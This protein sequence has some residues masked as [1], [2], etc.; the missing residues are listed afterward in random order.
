MAGESPDRSKQRESSEE[1]T[2]G[3]AGPVPGARGESGA[4]PRD[5]RLAVARE[6]ESTARGGVDMATRVFSRPPLP[7]EAEAAE[8]ADA[9][10]SADAEVAADADADARTADTAAEA[11]AEAASEPESA[12]R[13][14]SA[15]AADGTD[16]TGSTRLR[17]AVAA[18]VASADE[19]EGESEGV[20][21]AAEEH[22]PDG[23]APAGAPEGAEEPA[24]D[25]ADDPGPDGPPEAASGAPG[26]TGGASG[27]SGEDSSEP[28]SA[29]ESNSEPESKSGAEPKPEA[30]A[31]ETESAKSKSG[32]GT[33]SATGTESAAES[34]SRT[35]AESGTETKSAADAQTGTSTESESEPKSGTESGAKAPSETGSS[36]DSR[37]K[38][39]AK[40]DAKV[41]AAAGPASAPDPAPGEDSGDP[42]PKPFVDQPTAVFKAVR[43]PAAPPVDQPT[44]M[45]KL[46]DLAAAKPKGDA[47]ART[48]ADAK[49]DA[50]AAAKAD[51]GADAKSE[52]V[53]ER[54]SKFVALRPLDDPAT[55]KPPPGA[56][57]SAGSSK[58][59]AAATPA[60]KP[61]KVAAAEATAVVP[62]VGPER[63]TQQPLPPLP[64][65]DLLA[66]LTNTPPPRDTAV[67]SIA[68][69]VK[70]WTPVVV[71]LAIVFAVVQAFRP[72]PSP[73]LTLTA[74]DSYT[75]EGTAAALP[76]PSEGQGWM[77]VNGVGTMGKFGDQKPIAI[78]SVAKTMTAYVVLKGHALKTGEDGPSITVDPTAEKEGGYNQSGESTLNTVRAGDKLTLQQAISAIMIPSANNI[79]RLLARWDA[80]SEAAFIEKMNAAAKELGMTNTTYTD[81]SGL[82]ETTVSTAED[83]VRLGNAV[84]K[85]PALVAITSAA[86]WTD[87]SGYNWPN[88]NELPFKMGAIG[89]KTGST[90]AAGGNLLFAARK[91]V[92]GET[93]T[94]VG[95]VLGQHKPTILKTANEV[96]RTALT[97]AEDALVAA[98][99][100]KKGDVVGYV[101]DGLGG[102]T[103]VV[104]SKDVTA[105]GWAGRKV[106]LSFV[107][108]D[109]PHSAKAG[110]AVGSLTVGDGKGGA[111]KVPVQLQKDLV[112]PGFDKKLTRVG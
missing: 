49:T 55:R 14:D 45:L 18:W 58:A 20:E 15:H 59:P 70:I 53:A 28:E 12:A 52:S 96:S 50:E 80:G 1:P 38:S 65:L 95:A 64:P 74:E 25:V 3:S 48:G 5:P 37:P 40:P 105:V 33:D 104:L 27:D 51:A 21:G 17:A 2:S 11:K 9:D 41:E 85:I 87:P 90:S 62:Q 109:L 78:G 32:A 57:P 35:E 44:T 103:P 60:A 108:A 112:E 83:Q 101:D 76:W 89:I 75:F 106:E 19:G 23:D 77:D 100:L 7:T 67:R 13:P 56:T 81:P 82:K 29:Q 97:A 91:E 107:A 63:T 46:G 47:D 39:D 8:A 22:G 84:V 93:V 6:R 54:T 110:T 71:L 24:V 43:P 69:R 42:A 68:R 61:P 4:G 36:S 99:I 72:L 66:E 73:E 34:K 16:G 26:A 10:A 98:K 86:S 88:Y 79:A 31:A 92:G 94:I 30:A 111:V 102:Q